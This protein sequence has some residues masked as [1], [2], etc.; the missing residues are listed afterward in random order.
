M[1]FGSEEQEGI[2]GWYES[3]QRQNGSQS[4]EENI[5]RVVVEVIESGKETNEPSNRGGIKEERVVRAETSGG[6]S[7]DDAT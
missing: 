5:G 6:S 1:A 7:G 2:A 4:G 3:F